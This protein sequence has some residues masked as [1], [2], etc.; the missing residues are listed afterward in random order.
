M[1]TFNSLQV[2]NF[3]GFNLVLVL[4]ILLASCSE[5]FVFSQKNGRDGS[6]AF[7]L[8]SSRAVSDYSDV[9][10]WTLGGIGP[11]D[12]VFETM[13]S[14][15]TEKVALT[16]LLPGKWDIKIEGFDSTDKL[17]WLGKS[18]VALEAGPNAVSISL[19]RPIPAPYIRL[20]LNGDFAL[21]A[22]S[23]ATS[24]TA[25]TLL[26]LPG[27]GN[28]PSF[29]GTST[30]LG[31]EGSHFL[32]FPAQTSTSTGT[33]G[34]HFSLGTHV[35]GPTFSLS[36]WF[37]EVEPSHTDKLTALLSNQASVNLASKGYTL[38]L[39]NTGSA[40]RSIR[41]ITGDDISSAT[42][43]TVALDQFAFT[44]WN[45][46]VV[47]V[48]KNT[49]KVEIWLNG[50]L[51]PSSGT[52]SSAFY[53]DQELFVG[54]R[55]GAS[56]FI[57]ALDDIAIFPDFLNGSQVDMLYQKFKP[58]HFAGGTGKKTDPY[59]ISTADQL[60]KV[61]Y[62][63]HANF[64]QIAPINLGSYAAGLGWEPIGRS[65]NFPFKGSFDGMGMP[66]TGLVITRPT[67][68][69]T[70]LFGRAEGAVFKNMRLQDVDI[71]GSTYTAALVGYL[72][73]AT[74]NIA[75][76]TA[77]NPAV[78]RSSATGYVNGGTSQNIGGLVGYHYG[79]ASNL[80]Q[81]YITQSWAKVNVTG[82]SRVGGL[83]GYSGYYGIVNDCYAY[84]SVAGTAAPVGGLVGMAENGSDIARSWSAG[85]LTNGSGWGLIGGFGA[86][87]ALNNYYDKDTSGYTTGTV[88]I[89]PLTTAQMKVQTNLNGFDFSVVPIW[90]Y[91]A[92]SYP[93]LQ[94]QGMVDIPV[95]PPPPVWTVTFDPNG[96]TG[97]MPPQAISQ[98]SAQ[99]LTMNT[100][101]YL[102]FDFIGW[103]ILGGQG[104]TVGWNN[105]ASYT[106][107]NANTII[108]AQWQGY[109]T[110]M[111][112][113][114]TA[115]AVPSTLF[116]FPGIMAS[117]PLPGALGRTGFVFDGWNTLADGS[118]T[119]YMG[120]ASMVI[121]ATVTLHA[122][123]LGQISYDGNGND[124]GTVPGMQPYFAG[125]SGTL[126]MQGS[127]SRTGFTFVGWNTQADG[128]GTNYPAGSPTSALPGNI[129]LYAKW[130]P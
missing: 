30:A 49:E 36:L 2:R 101:T 130:I 66:I 50:T 87:A 61:R 68:L 118:G 1:K 84:G 14:A 18:T 80:Y 114:N 25:P 60:N 54:A 92:G 64:R 95:P 115:G 102:G 109:A 39:N 96:G 71:T 40:D 10:R 94:W 21:S 55:S 123:W 126:A 13:A 41:F 83:I 120:G 111:G 3:V 31:I 100:F 121:P 28:A 129:T 11:N 24:Y 79:N 76:Y 98:G 44:A 47:N 4:V 37:A 63:Y 53:P 5:V 108:Y 48:D 16:G 9:A 112:N 35:L 110:F 122:R 23:K 59:L 106:M 46:L 8:P 22:D 103:S 104:Q 20:G 42:W 73:N 58:S 26:S 116:F 72:S 86:S 85:A 128:L 89:T 77:A 75:T 105:A 33:N 78:F 81:S 56:H 74:T 62:A 107:G 90:K 52:L 6:L 51:V 99:N 113:G 12:T 97:S 17:V 125:G 15:G 119:N 7:E 67:E 88:N 117:I 43:A 29:V 19:V 82:A 34:K 124:G 93:Y 91:N 70:G 57:G 27:T 127:M 32:N 69:E 65:T 45:H 38:A